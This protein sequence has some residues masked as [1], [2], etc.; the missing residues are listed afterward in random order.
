MPSTATTRNRFEKQGSGENPNSWGTRL[1]TKTTDLVDAAL[2]GVESYTLSGTKTLTST[3]YAADEARMRVQNITGGTGGTVTIPGVQKWYLVR[4]ASSGS[5]TFTTGSGETA[6]VASG[7]LAYVMC[8]GTNCYTTTLSVDL[9]DLVTA[10]AGLYQTTSA[11]S[12]A[13]GTGSKSFTIG[14][15]KG[16]LAGDYMLIADSAAPT[17]NYMWGKVTSYNSTT[18]ALVFDCQRIGGSGTKTSWTVNLSGIN[19]AAG[20]TLPSFSG[21][22]S[23]FLQLD[24]AG[25]V[26]QWTDIGYTQ[27]GTSSPS[28]SASPV[29]FTSIP[30]TY[31][32]LLLVVHPFVGAGAQ[33]LRVELSANGSSWSNTLQIFST[34]AGTHSGTVE[35][36][37]YTAGQGRLHHTHLDSYGAS[38]SVAYGTATNNAIWVVTGGIQA[39]RISVSSGNLTGT[40]TLYG[41]F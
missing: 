35:I 1:N 24:S 16:Y 34:A 33:T 23:K 9:D 25:N 5:V 3:N 41:K 20:D 32:E 31:N 12:N 13:I 39:I 38:P 17:T 29:T 19:G 21:N 10:A 15:S 30:Q 6:A 2:D 14:V 4:N 11:T 26:T 27:I 8:D 7:F 37:R 18:G 22:G 28:A 40:F 36:P